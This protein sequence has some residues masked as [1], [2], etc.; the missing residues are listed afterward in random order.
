MFHPA[1]KLTFRDFG[2]PGF[3]PSLDRTVGNPVQGLVDNLETFPSL[4]DAL[5][6]AIVQVPGLVGGDVKVE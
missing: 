2:I 6:I 3:L 4:G 5:A 1:I